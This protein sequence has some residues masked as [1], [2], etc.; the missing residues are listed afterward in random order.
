MNRQIDYKNSFEHQFGLYQKRSMFLKT[1]GNVLF[2]LTTSE[3]KL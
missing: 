1:T 3:S 2:T